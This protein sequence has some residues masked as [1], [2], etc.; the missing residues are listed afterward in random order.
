MSRSRFGAHPAAT[1]L[2]KANRTWQLLLAGLALLATPA[3]A[4]VQ[5][6]AEPGLWHHQPRSLRYQP[7]GEDFV[8]RNGNRRFTRA[9]YGT[10]TA[11]RVEAGDLPEFALYLPGM[12]GN[13]KFGLLAGGQ[14]K[15]LTQASQIE[16]R[17]RPGAMLYEIQ[18]PILGAQGRLLLTVLAMADA[19]G[20]LVKAE[21]QNVAPN[22][23]SFVWAFG[24]VTGKKFSRDGDI[25]ADPES[26]FYLKPENC[27]GN[28]I[29]LSGSSFALAYGAEVKAPNGTAARRQLQGVMPTQSKLRVTNATQQETPAALWAASVADAPA[30]A[31]QVGVKQGEALYFAV[32]KA[33]EVA[34][35]KSTPLRYADLPRAFTAAEQARRQLTGRV[36]VSTPDPFLN[37]LGGALSVAADAIWEEPSYMHG[38]VAWRMRLNGWR[39][40]Y[41]ADPLGWH[42]RARQHFRAYAQSQLEQPE[43]G[44]VAMD[45]ALNLARHQEKLG[46]AVFSRGYISRNPGGDF[47]PHHYDMNLVFIDE[48]LRHLR[49]TGDL[50]F[51]REMWPVLSRH[52]AWEKRNFDPDGDGLYDAYAAIWASDALQYSGG[53]VTHSS[54]YNYLANQMA[55][56]LAS[57][58]GQDPAPYRQEAARIKQALNSRLW[59][60]AKGW[61]AEYQDAL[62]L[63]QLHPAA[64]LWTVYHALDSEV[65]DAFQAYQAL[66][67]VESELPRIPVRAAGLS[68]DGYYLLSTTNWQPYDWSINN[69]ALAEVLHTTLANWQAGRADEAFKLW[70]SALLESMY[71]GSSPGNFQQ[72]S[73]YDANR[74]E[75]Y[76]DFADPIGV[77][78]RSLVEGLFG[79][80][81]DAL[82]GTLLVRPGLPSAW[83]QAALTVPDVSFDFRREG[84]R[85]TYT[86]ASRLPQPLKLRLQVPARAAN[87]QGVQVNGRPAEWKNLPDAVGRPTIEIAAEPASNYVVEIYWQGEAP[88]VAAP[89]TVY[90][91]GSTYAARFPQAS[92]LKVFDPQQV[93]R[94][95]RTSG[96]ELTAQ[97]AGEQGSRTAFVQLQQ[98]ALSWWEPLRLR[99]KPTAEIVGYTEQADGSLRF[100]VQNYAGTPLQG[101]LQLNHGKAAY[102]TNV[103]AAALGASELITIPAA[104]ASTGR[105][106]L[107]LQVNGQPVATQQLLTWTRPAAVTSKWE[108]V[109][110]GRYFNDEVGNIFR[111]DKYVSPRPAGPTLQLPTQGIG[112][113]CYPLVL[114]KIDDAGL[115]QKAGANNEIQLPVGVPLQTP[116]AAGAKNILFVSQWDNYP[117]QATV[118][119]KG[120]ASHAYLLMA[121][122]TNPMQSQLTNGE[123]VVQ[124]SDGST[125][126]LPLRNPDTWW[127]IEQD[128]ADDGFAFQTGA[129]KPFRVHL[130]SGLITREFKEYGSIKG[131]STRTVEGGA[132][133]VL[134]LPLDPSKKLKSLTVRALANDVVIGLMSVTLNRN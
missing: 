65:P 58:I 36:K 112:N 114:P 107:S 5:V 62:G 85:E 125:A 133:T 7:E 132:A 97:V 71:L 25:G 43:I 53:G 95:V 52:L 128:Y 127:P 8:I 87:V 42:D 61:Y 19:E 123:V 2:P 67:Y 84:T 47:R 54:A 122:S 26:N 3:Q 20:A 126:T 91:R 111:A 51:V 57:R 90:P 50:G 92:I 75:L 44:P 96:G 14:S 29:T 63:K 104:H 102:T 32:L 35:A 27:R 130:K 108:K 38:A 59:M 78:A 72:V 103:T 73:F 93:L 68:D 6:A 100:R 45:T 117:E 21:F 83:N 40:P 4:Q 10:N 131:F 74:G 18:D 77:A 121:G 13:L 15:W 81:P 39:G 116:G 41:A 94:E 86:L 70:K 79:I 119:L 105:N 89:E 28:S 64:G 1:R 99:V 9:L 101:K 134:D 24:G 98:G 48:L 23:V 46:N 88:A 129:P 16:A 37:T 113:W 12:G 106:H 17:Y 82:S 56:E 49:W 34:S 33:P 110:L 80:R 31:G 118:P 11:F 60:P 69:V 120:R 66:R 22:Q 55:A 30:V 115:R 124:Y 76:R 109:D